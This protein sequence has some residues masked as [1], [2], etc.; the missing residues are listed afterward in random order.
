M[1]IHLPDDIAEINLKILDGFA[2]QATASMQRDIKNGRQSELD[3]L[4]CQ[5][6]RMGEQYHVPVP[7]YKETAEKLLR[8]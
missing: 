8:P 1:G 5:V 6:V 7:V 2:P 4:V 3:G